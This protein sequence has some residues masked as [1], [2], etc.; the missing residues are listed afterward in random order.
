MQHFYIYMHV[1]FIV[2]PM[3]FRHNKITEI[4]QAS[5]KKIEKNKI[6]R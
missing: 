4:Q 5:T 2:F 3:D 6:E 1:F